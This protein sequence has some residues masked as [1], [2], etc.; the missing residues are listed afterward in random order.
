MLFSKALGYPFQ[1][2]QPINM[3]NMTEADFQIRKATLAD[4]PQLQQ[5]IE[6]SVRQLQTPDYSQAQI[7][8][9]LGTIF[10]VDT[11]LILDGTYFVASTPES[12]FAGC[13]GWSKR[14]TL[15]GSDHAA[16]RQAE[17]L[18]PSTEAA[19][20]RAFFVHPLWA[21]KGV[22]TAILSV[23]ENAAIQAGFLSFELGAT[24][25]G[26]KLYSM[27]G[28]TAEARILQPLSNGAKLPIVRMVKRI[29]RKEIR[30]GGAIT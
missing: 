10:G 13:G 23:C 1:T 8:G 7:D 21:R 26:Q 5:L 17:L 19:K 3:W 16:V 24:L 25:T 27:R 14:R 22:G 30:D 15:F 9:A 6:L 12:Q 20:I 28:Y 11:Q 4:I 29:P 18:D 2:I